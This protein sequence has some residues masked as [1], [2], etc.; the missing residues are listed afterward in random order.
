MA[1]IALTSEQQLEVVKRVIADDLIEL[2]L[3]PEKDAAICDEIQN[4]WCALE[5]YMNQKD[6]IRL[7][8]TWPQLADI[9]L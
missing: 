1:T 2:S 7:L 4:L 6:R 5:Y 3:L 9:I 8:E